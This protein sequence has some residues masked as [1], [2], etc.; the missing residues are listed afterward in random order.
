MTLVTAVIDADVSNLEKVQA[1]FKEA[2]DCMGS[3]VPNSM[4]EL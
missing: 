3:R 4:K 2:A 1:A